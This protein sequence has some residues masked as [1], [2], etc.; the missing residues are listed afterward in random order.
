MPAGVTSRPID[1]GSAYFASKSSHS[2]WMDRHVLLGA[3]LEQPLNATEVGYDRAMGDNIYW[4]LA[5]SPRDPSNLRADYN[6]IRAGGMHASAPDTTANSGSETV[7]YDGS[8]ESDLNFGPGSNRWLN[9]NTYNQDAC[10][11]P[12]S[13]CGF[14]VAK[15]FYTGQPS[16]D[17]SLGYPINGTAIH[18]GYGKGVLFW[19]TK[20]QA[21]QFLKYSDMLSADSYWLTDSGLQAPS[22]GGCALLP[23]N[24]TACGNGSG[25]G[26]TYAQSHLPANYAYDVTELEQ[27]QAS[28]GRSKPVVVDV[29]TGCP[30]SGGGNTG[31]CATPAQTVAAAWH[32]LIAGARGI[33]WF[34]HNFSGP[35]PD[36]RT[37]I[38]GSNP[39]SRMYSC[40]QTPGVTLHN[41]VQAI[42]AFNQE[43][44][45]LNGVLLSPSAI[46]YVST[47]GDVSTVAKAYRGSCYVFAGS[48]QLATPPPVDQSVTFK[49]ADG[50][51]GPVTV[52]D[53]NRT[54]QASGGTFTDTFAD[55]N[56]T[57]IYH[58]Q[59]GSICARPG[60]AS[61]SIHLSARGAG[62][63]SARRSD[64]RPLLL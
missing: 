6:V 50:Y 32:A 59:G 58:I 47:T 61:R 21:A 16:S 20:Q 19:E 57:H 13:R 15:F 45:H 46:G 29:E 39:S 25:P 17:R 24:R 34:Q 11:P 38:D 33:L 41:M 18:Q 36:D 30:F 52:F 54:V 40:Q 42:T 2:G 5:G 8:D 31:H 22:Q 10:A 60:L 37:F 44:A 27:L 28:T 56:A 7:A 51:S 4:N 12:G 3:W 35:C 49:L 14:T 53:E 9:N 63:R 64:R 43:V 23:N 1:G 62:A 48:G 26:L 55:A